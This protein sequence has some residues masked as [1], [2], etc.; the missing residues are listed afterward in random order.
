MG[1]LFYGNADE[2]IEMPDRILAHLKVLISTKLRR[3]ESFSLSWDSLVDG[4]VERSSLWLHCS[5]P[6]KFQLD[7]EATKALDREYLQQL[8][9]AA[10]TST[11]VVVDLCDQVAEIEQLPKKEQHV[12]SLARA[13]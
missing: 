13:A 12:R 1:K 6:L 10:T 3:N 8:A 11:G 2:P 4:V 9:T 7:A 5:I